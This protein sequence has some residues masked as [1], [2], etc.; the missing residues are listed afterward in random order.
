MSK[1]EDMENGDICTICESRTAETYGRPGACEDCGGD[2]VLYEDTNDY[3]MRAMA[4]EL[5]DRA[6]YEPNDEKSK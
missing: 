1:L 2:F 5:K 6:K 3:K 4:D